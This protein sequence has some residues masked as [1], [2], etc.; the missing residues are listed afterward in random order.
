MTLR[1]DIL[2]FSRFLQSQLRGCI[3]EPRLLSGR[4]R[5]ATWTLEVEPM[6]GSLGEESGEWRDGVEGRV[7]IIVEMELVIP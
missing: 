5:I 2:R 1:Q 3:G 6:I 7:A 4:T